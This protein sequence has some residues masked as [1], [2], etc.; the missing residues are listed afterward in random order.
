M[1]LNKEIPQASVEKLTDDKLKAYELGAYS[2]KQEQAREEM[3]RLSDYFP[4]DR[5]N[6]KPDNQQEVPEEKIKQSLQ[7]YNENNRLVS[8]FYESDP[9][10]H[11]RESMLAEINE[12][13]SQLEEREEEDSEEEKQ[14]A[15]MEKSYQMAA[16]YLPGTDP[17]GL[18]AKGLPQNAF[19]KAGASSK[20]TTPHQTVS[21]LPAM[22]VLPESKQVVSSLAQP[23]TD[24]AFIMEYAS[25]ERQ[26]G[27]HSLKETSTQTAAR[28]T[29]RVAVD[30]TTTL[31]EGD[32]VA[33]RLLESVKL[34][35]MIIP[36]GE[37]LMAQAKIE[38]NR[39]RLS[40][41]SVRVK[42]QIVGVK[43]TA[44]DTDGQQGVY[45][46]G[47]QEVTAIREAAANIGGSM[48][49][50]FT[51]A[52]SAKDQIISEAARGVMQGASG[53]LQKKM[54]TVKI[55]LKSGYRL[56]LVQTK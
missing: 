39:M 51:F 36:R 49:T 7:R 44:Y 5:M 45:I 29:L 50:S 34:Q 13:K 12:L 18:E 8:S 24:S 25:K 52:S 46:P 43:L 47:S 56:F 55:T 27:F 26:H 54:R 11:E 32:Y 4:D 48:G 3:G 30:R 40:V 42:G 17:Q 16:K 53:L 14:L 22:E 2:E 41:Q 38:G 1:G 23:I 35:E 37:C 9:F 6:P 33:L 31:K 28:N 21:Q 20:G 15:L 10:E 19:V